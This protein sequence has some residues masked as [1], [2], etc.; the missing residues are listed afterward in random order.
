MTDADPMAPFFRNGRSR[1]LTLDDYATISGL[2]RAQAQ[3]RLGELA[4]AGKIS[5]VHRNRTHPVIFE[6][7]EPT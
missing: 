2:D 7:A 5:R 3:K 4:D 6:V 1:P